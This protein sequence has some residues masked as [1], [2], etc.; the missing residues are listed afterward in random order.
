MLVYNRK[1]SWISMDYAT[2]V[3]NETRLYRD[4][5]EIHGL[6]EIF[7]YWSNRY[8]RPKLEA[9]GF[10]TP[11]QMFRK[12]IVEQCLRHQERPKRFVSLGSGNCDLE[13]GLARELRTQGHSDFVIDCIDLN[14]TMLERGRSAA[15]S[16]GVEAHLNFVQADLNEWKP[17]EKYD[18]AIANQALHHVLRLEDLFAGIKSSLDPGGTL[19]VSEVCGRN[20]HERWPEALDIVREFWR[21]LPPSYRF[22]RTLERYEEMYQNFDCSGDGF[23][24][25]R[26]EDI[27]PLLIENFHFHLFIAFANVIEPFVD[28]AFGHNFDA[29]A[30]WDR[31]FIDRVHQR[32][33]EEFARGGLKPTHILAVLGSEPGVSQLCLEPLTPEFSVRDPRQQSG[34]PRV[35]ANPYEWHSWPHSPQAELEIASQRLGVAYR[36]L[37]EAEKRI[38]ERGEM[39]M[40]LTAAFE[41]RTGWALELKREVEEWKAWALHVQREM[42]EW[43]KLRGHM[44]LLNAELDERTRWA[45]ELQEELE[46]LRRQFESRTNWALEL[47][48]EL[49]ARKIETLQLG[50]DLERLRW[51]RA[52]DRRFHGPLEKGFRMLERIRNRFRAV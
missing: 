3:T 29:Q 50:Q 45:M 10:S 37:E 39:V 4:L 6:P 8:V 18:A 52:L 13:I 21:K 20:G 24:A 7:H 43:K 11:E 46:Q 34:E 33:E 26:S 42:E 9:F 44:E 32:D 48:R 35:W 30:Q 25:I 27:L 1:S 36:K 14:G 5:V 19:M 51:A 16:H 41:E 38:E 12:Y 47:D 22:N 31:N 2:R 49:E 23:E 40:N 15:A 17:D 28:R